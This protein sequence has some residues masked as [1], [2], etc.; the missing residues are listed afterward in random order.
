MGTWRLWVA[1]VALVVTCGSV[2][3]ANLV[4]NGSFEE[5]DIG[6]GGGAGF[7]VFGA[8]QTIGP[9]VVE[10]NNVD[11][12]G[13]AGVFAWQ[14]ID[15]RQSVDMAGSPGAGIIY[16]DLAT[17]PGQQYRLRF[18]LSGNPVANI[19]T[20]KAVEIY[21]G[22]TLV[23]MPTF[24]ITG[25]SSSEMGWGYIEYNLTAPTDTTRLRFVSPID[26]DGGAV[27]DDVSVTVVPEPGAVAALLIAGTATLLGRRSLPGRII[28]PQ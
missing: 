27:I 28:P 2:R 19:P 7:S 20:V 6:D 15:G 14:Q 5:P 4:A 21:W 11:V 12:V 22:D 8:G 25:H 9:W 24:D 3:A 10:A 16:Q 17:V 18:A 1:A 23:D 26:T 13:S